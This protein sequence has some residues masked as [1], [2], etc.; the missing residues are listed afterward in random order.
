MAKSKKDK[1][2]ADVT[3]GYET[4]IKD[5]KVNKT[6]GKKFEKA[7]KSAAKQRGSK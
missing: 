5:K 2:M 6:G 1:T 7:V 4:F 3:A